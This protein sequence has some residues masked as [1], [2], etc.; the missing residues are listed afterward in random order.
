MTKPNNETKEIFA[1]VQISGFI[2]AQGVYCGKDH[3]GRDCVR[4]GDRVIAGQLI[5]K[6]ICSTGL[7]PV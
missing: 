1:T 2:S 4:E 7:S 6:P 3:R 5:G